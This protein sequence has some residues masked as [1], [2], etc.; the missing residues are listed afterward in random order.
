MHC[1]KA[2]KP[3]QQDPYGMVHANWLHALD[4]GEEE[5]LVD[6]GQHVYKTG[7]V[8]DGGIAP[9]W[10]PRHMPDVEI[11]WEPRL[12]HFS[13]VRI[14]KLTLWDS[15]VGMGADDVIGEGVLMPSMIAKAVENPNV[16]QSV[17]EIALTTVEEEDGNEEEDAGVEHGDA[18][19]DSNADRS[20]CRAVKRSLWGHAPVGGI[21]KTCDGEMA[22]V[23]LTTESC[24]LLHV[25]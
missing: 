15:D 3:P 10:L 11:P 7:V 14:C 13:D 12:A 1:T 6:L 20:L 16:E 23:E 22:R 18:N 17:L 24:Q 21:A 25:L 8:Q 2:K 9:V 4:E 5:S 19:I